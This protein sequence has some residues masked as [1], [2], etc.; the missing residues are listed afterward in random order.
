M[1]ELSELSFTLVGIDPTEPTVPI[2]LGVEPTEPTVPISVRY[3][4]TIAPLMLSGLDLT[5]FFYRYLES[6]VFKKEY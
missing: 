5:V 1:A 6:E 2:S 4:W 3:H